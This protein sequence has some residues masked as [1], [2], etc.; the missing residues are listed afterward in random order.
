LASAGWVLRCVVGGSRFSRKSLKL[1]NS[2]EGR[3]YAS[4]GRPFSYTSFYVFTALRVRA[5]AF[6]T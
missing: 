6:T 2:G 3:S 1:L 4:W 5:P